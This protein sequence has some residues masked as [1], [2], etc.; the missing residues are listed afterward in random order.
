MK[1]QSIFSISA[2]V[3][4]FSCCLSF[5]PLQAQDL[6]K[7]G[8][9]GEKREYLANSPTQQTSYSGTST[10]GYPIQIQLY[11]LVCKYNLGVFFGEPVEHWNFKYVLGTKVVTNI[12]WSEIYLMS[13]DFRNKK[14]DVEYGGRGVK[15]GVTKDIWQKI[16]VVD[17][18][19]IAMTHRTTAFHGPVPG[20]LGKSG[21]WGWDMTGSPNWNQAITRQNKPLDLGRGR[22][23]FPDKSTYLPEK[24]AKAEWKKLREDQRSRPRGAFFDLKIY[25]FKVDLVD[26]LALI[27]KHEPGSTRYL[28]KSPPLGKTT[29][30]NSKKKPN[31][32]NENG[33]DTQVESMINDFHRR[34]LSGE[35]V[36]RREKA[37]NDIIEGLD[38]GLNSRVRDQWKEYKT[39]KLRL[40]LLPGIQKLADQVQK[41]LAKSSEDRPQVSEYL[42]K[43]LASFELR[44]K[45]EKDVPEDI[46]KLWLKLSTFSADRITDG[47]QGKL[48]V[49][50]TISSIS[51]WIAPRVNVNNFTVYGFSGSDLN[52]LVVA[53]D[54]YN[55]KVGAFK[56]STGQKIWEVGLREDGVTC[57]DGEHI[58]FQGALDPG[59]AQWPNLVIRIRDGKRFHRN[60]NSFSAPRHVSGLLYSQVNRIRFRAPEDG[61]ARIFFPEENRYVEVPDL[62]PQGTGSIIGYEFSTHKQLWRKSF[63]GWIDSVYGFGDRYVIL[64]KFDFERGVGSVKTKSLINVVSGKTL[65][66]LRGKEEAWSSHLQ[67]EFTRRAIANQDGSFLEISE[68]DSD[69]LQ[70]RDISSDGR[71]V[72][73][74]DSIVERSTNRT[75]GHFPR[76]QA[77][78]ITSPGDSSFLSGDRFYIT[79]QGDLLDLAPLRSGGSIKKVFDLGNNTKGWKFLVNKEKTLVLFINRY[80]GEVKLFK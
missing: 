1:I 6:V 58:I 26:V 78:I 79:W 12:G 40:R 61:L 23:K 41:E 37:I 75:I 9:K 69:Y 28:F 29:K 53:L 74:K 50:K 65:V 33:L 68:R 46:K 8:I 16:K 45:A 48:L 36:A 38:F 71:W 54:N 52:D 15:I 55:S 4:L 5:T 30:P 63:S 17:F 34:R 11:D 10:S 70:V 43:Q 44:L 22:S 73:I 27:E 66:E 60:K 59:P 42:K 51:S 21:E 35:N 24:E 80:S 19:F 47:F 77:Q 32:L 72:V 31:P 56:I 7:G 13:D 57:F 25:G 18:N 67:K 14:V 76:N 64:S 39:Q 3:V 20:I 62:K 49:S 2:F